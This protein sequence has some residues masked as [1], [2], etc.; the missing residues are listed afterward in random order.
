MSLRW[1]LRALSFRLK[2]KYLNLFF[3]K[4]TVKGK[5]DKFKE[6]NTKCKIQK[7]L[8][9]RDLQNKTQWKYHSGCMG[10]EKLNLTDNHT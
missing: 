6:W 4:S 5:R 8:F 3:Q 1:K 10:K 9:K 2:M 7:A